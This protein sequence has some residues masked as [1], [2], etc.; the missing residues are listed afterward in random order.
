[1]IAAF[2]RVIA[3]VAIGL[4]LLIGAVLIVVIF[5]RSEP[6]ARLAQGIIV[7]SAIALI[8]TGIGFAHKP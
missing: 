3:G 5:T 1:M 4:L 2:G 8:G 6:V 7:L